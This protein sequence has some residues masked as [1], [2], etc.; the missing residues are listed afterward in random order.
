MLD[1][2]MRDRL[3]EVC[4][5]EFERHVGM[6]LDV[7]RLTTIDGCAYVPYIDELYGV[8]ADQVTYRPLKRAVVA[9]LARQ[10]FAWDAPL[11]GVLPLSMRTCQAMIDDPDPSRSLVGL[12]GMS[13]R[14]MEWN[15]AIHPSFAR[16]ASG[17]MA[18][19]HTPCAV[20]CDPKLR[21]QFPPQPLE[22]LA[23]DDWC[24][25]T[26][27]KIA[28]DRQFAAWSKDMDARREAGLPHQAFDDEWQRA[29]PVSMYAPFQV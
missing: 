8:N 6:L 20:R 1:R 24:W 12:Y 2:T 16:Y 9:L 10:R 22:G 13:L 17:L 15:C 28:E 14:G 4:E 23:D 3:L 5:R 29:H 11:E 26:P 7:N 19:P 27:E 18:F 21:E 25:R